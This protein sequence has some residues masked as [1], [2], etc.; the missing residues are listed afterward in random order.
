MWSGFLE[1]LKF[2]GVMDNT[3]ICEFIQ[4]LG[5]K[6]AEEL[7]KAKRIPV[8]QNPEV[9]FG[10]ANRFVVKPVQATN[11]RP[12]LCQTPIL[13]WHQAIHSYHSKLSQPLK[14][15]FHHLSEIQLSQTNKRAMVII[16]QLSVPAQLLT[17]IL[18]VSI[19]QAS[20][21]SVLKLQRSTWN[22]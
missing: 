4:M 8:Q 3:N 2:N 9:Y 12:L 16:H 5:N 20:L 11:H 15:L 10:N 22:C 1:I 18:F 19:L 14:T 21:N 13:L 6:N 7:R 17:Q